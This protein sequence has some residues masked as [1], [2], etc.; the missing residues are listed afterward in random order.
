[1]RHCTVTMW[2]QGY[3]CKGALRRH[4]NGPLTHPPPP[5]VAENRAQEVSLLDDRSELHEMTHSS[6]KL[7]SNVGQQKRPENSDYCGVQTRTLLMLEER[8][9][10]QIRKECA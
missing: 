5:G 6:Y 4:Q 1:M 8:L 9:E 7:P 3:I 2:V 10:M